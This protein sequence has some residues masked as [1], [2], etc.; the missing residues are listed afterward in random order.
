M[1]SLVCGVAFILSVALLFMAW[2]ALADE[3]YLKNGD[4][5]TG[6]IDTSEDG[7]LIVRTGYAKKIKIVWDEVICVT[8]DK[9]VTLL[10]KNN[11]K[12]VG[13]V[14]CPDLGSIQLVDQNTGE[15]RD[16]SL[17]DLQMINPPPPPPPVTY[18]A[19]I[20]AG[21]AIN[22]GNTDTKT[23]NSSAKFQARSER[24]RLFLEG[25]FNYGESDGDENE[26]NWLAGAKYDY[27]W[28]RKI[29]SFLRPFAEYDKF[30]GLDLRFVLSA[31]PGYQFI[32]TE[33]TS[34]FA[35]LGPAYF[36]EDYDTAEDKEYVAARWAAG[37]K[38]D[39]IAEKIKFFH[40][41]ELYYDLS[42]D[43]GSY[44]R[45][46]QGLRFALIENFFF[47][48][49]VNYKYKSDPPKDNKSSDTSII[50]GL[51]YELNF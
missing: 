38:F 31:G 42:S 50:L 41:Q 47:N 51:G 16:L 24:Q 13:R 3:V 15:T 44:L 2:P 18:K 40:L 21:G 4:L 46:E 22:K 27:F 30:Q 29:Y 33:T 14:V 49:Q 1:R 10:L 20:D 43:E 28:T 45:T 11:E 39:I 36:Y 26:R 7:M 12:L 35:E 8:S 19:I 25:K 37:V 48:F 23:F 34:L 5:I 32:D 6:E 17:A 9:E